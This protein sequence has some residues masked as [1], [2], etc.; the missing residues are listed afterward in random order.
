MV[1]GCEDQPV[2]CAEDFGNLKARMTEAERKIEAIFTKMEIRE[3]R[4]DLKLDAIRE[5]LQCI[6]DKVNMVR[7]G[8]KTMV[9]IAAVVSAG[10]TWVLTY[11][12]G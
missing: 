7:G 9:T 3:A 8:W 5:S 4:I 6:M 10:I 2:Q 12:K 11:V 1:Q